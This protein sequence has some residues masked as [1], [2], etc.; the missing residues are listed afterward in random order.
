MVNVMPAIDVQYP[1]ACTACGSPWLAWS[2]GTWF[3]CMLCGAPRQRTT[4]AHEH[5]DRDRAE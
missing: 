3:H 5:A 1:R 4:T 2:S